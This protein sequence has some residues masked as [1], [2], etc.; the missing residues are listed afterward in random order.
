MTEETN[1]YELPDYDAMW[2][3]IQA[4][5]WYSPAVHIACTP[6]WLRSMR[7][8]QEPGRDDWPDG[9]FGGSVFFGT[10]VYV[11]D[12][13]TDPRGWEARPGLQARSQP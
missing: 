9:P 2:K 10:S 5:R 6:E 12:D 13:V 8:L 7:E 11:T 4:S 3:A 1:V